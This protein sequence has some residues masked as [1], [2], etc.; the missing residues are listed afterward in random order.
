L[1]TP[2][3]PSAPPRELWNAILTGFRTARASFVTASM[4]NLFGAHV[5]TIV[6]ATIMA[7]FERIV[8]AADSLALERCVQIMTAY[9][10]TEKLK[11]LAGTPLLVLQGDSD[12]SMPYE[13]GVRLIETLVPDTRVSMY[14]KGAH[15]IYVT[16]AQKVVD[17][18]LGFVQGRKEA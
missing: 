5:G 12:Q 16:H 9:D 15:G 1:Q 17:D 8:D 3:N 10:F 4:P 14:E 11:A 7:R 13:A 18:I 2:E 6:D